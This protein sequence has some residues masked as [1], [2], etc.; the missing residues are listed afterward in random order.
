MGLLNYLLELTFQEL[1]V[2]SYS[3]QKLLFVLYTISV[4]KMLEEG[5][6]AHWVDL[7]AHC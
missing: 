3:F 6:V 7:L 4:V 1:K 2:G 5:E